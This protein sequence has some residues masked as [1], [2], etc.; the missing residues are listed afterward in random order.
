[1][2]SENGG[3]AFVLIYILSVAIIALPIMIAEVFI[4]RHGK[5]NPVASLNYLSNESSSFDITE[6]DN[7]LNRVTTRKQKYSNSDD[8]KLMRRSLLLT[9]NGISAGLKNTG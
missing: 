5:Q 3:G 8:Y 9:I 7:R 4:G 1:M 2:T 6:I